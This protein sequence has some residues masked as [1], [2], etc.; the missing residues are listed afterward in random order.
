MYEEYI[1]R[2]Y[3]RWTVIGV[4]PHK[5]CEKV[6]LLCRC[7]CGT[8]KGVN[9]DNLISG[10]T[11]SCGCRASEVTTMRNYK[12]GDARSRLFKVWCNMRRRCYEPS[13]KRWMQY[14]GK[15]VKVCDEW[16]GEHGYENFKKWAIESGYDVTAEYFA[17]TI[18]RID[19]DGDYEPSN[20][21]WVDMKTQ[22][23]NRTSNVHIRYKGIDKIAVEWSEL[24]GVRSELFCN[25]IRC[26]WTDDMTIETPI[27]G[28]EKE[29]QRILKEIAS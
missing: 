1:G 22:C 12:H 29:W 19:V 17:C 2:K 18:D 27:K 26:G 13:N 20:C 16:Q 6:K 15:G 14:G 8:E 9:K 21:R 25:R 7:D 24:F 11:L 28:R 3:G 4:L 10:K 23:R 5:P